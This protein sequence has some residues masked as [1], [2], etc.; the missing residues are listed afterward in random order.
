MNTKLKKW[1]VFQ[2]AF[3]IVQA[4][5]KDNQYSVLI[6]LYLIMRELKLHSDAKSSQFWWYQLFFLICSQFFLYFWILIIGNCVP[7]SFL[8]RRMR[9]VHWQTF[10]VEYWTKLKYHNWLM[11]WLISFLE[12]LEKSSSLICK[13][14]VLNSS[15]IL[16]VVLDH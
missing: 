3:F 13:R 1:T 8:P 14:R 4:F 5:Q 10:S 9:K 16:G 6:S 15:E 7:D 11:I 12:N 2:W